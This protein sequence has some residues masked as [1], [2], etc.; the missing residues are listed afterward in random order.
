MTA[1]ECLAAS[2]LA[3]SEQHG[4]LCHAE[5]GPG[6]QP[7]QWP[8][9]RLGVGAHE[10]ADY[11]P[12]NDN[13]P[14]EVLPRCLRG[15][16]SGGRH[17]RCRQQAIGATSRNRLA[18]ALLFL[19]LLSCPSL[20]SMVVSNLGCQ[21]VLDSVPRGAL[22]RRPVSSAQV[23]QV[24]LDGIAA[25]WGSI[26]VWFSD[27]HLRRVLRALRDSVAPCYPFRLIH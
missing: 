2:L 23:L 18:K 16:A 8:L 6:V 20:L 11:M 9:P 12:P 14:P 24:L 17:H 3:A 13:G 19:S 25:V 10:G 4:C 22:G 1:A 7:P 15:G 21:C 27:G 5:V 26:P